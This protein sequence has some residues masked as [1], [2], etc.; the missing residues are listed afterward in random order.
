MGRAWKSLLEAAC[1]EL[2]PFADNYGD[3]CLV[4]VNGDFATVS[5]APLA[6]G[7]ADSPARGGGMTARKAR[8]TAFKVDGA[9]SSH[10]R[11]KNKGVAKLGHTI[12]CADS[13][14]ESGAEPAFQLGEFSVRLG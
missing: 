9:A 13:L 8:A 10:L 7:E 12:V 1:F 6:P 14:W 4:T 2:L 11:H 3:L 5:G